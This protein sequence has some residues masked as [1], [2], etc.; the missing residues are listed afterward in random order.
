MVSLA[1]I[2]ASFSLMVAMAIMVASFRGSVDRWLATLLPAD[3]Y[4]RTTHAGE[5]AYLRARA[6]VGACAACRRWR[7][8]SS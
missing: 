7:A 6:G 8:P 3:L 4:L 1:A 2:V 5:T